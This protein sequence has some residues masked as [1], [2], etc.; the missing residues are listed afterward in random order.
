MEK[1]IDNKAFDN[2]IQN[3]LRVL[4][5]DAQA[6]PELYTK[7][8]EA[9]EPLVVKALE[10]AVDSLNVNVE[11]KYNSGGYAFPDIVVI[12]E[13]GEKYGIEVKSSTAKGNS[14]K[15]NGNSVMGSTSEPGIIRNVIIFGK[16]RLRNCIFRAKDYEDSIANVVVTHSPRYYIDLDLEDGDTFFEK[17][18]ISYKDLVISENPIGL[19]TDYFSSQGHKAWWLAESTPAAIRQFGDLSYEEQ[20]EVLGYAF[21]HFPEIMSKSSTKFSR[22]TS[23]LATENSIVDASLRDKFTAGGKVDLSVSGHKY[24]RLPQIFSKMHQYRELILAELEI[25]DTDVLQKDWSCSI[26]DSAE[27]RKTKWIE[28]VSE[29]ISQDDIPNIQADELLRNIMED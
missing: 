19:I 1:N 22:F 12:A 9:F 25:C 6:H 7:S 24:N 13:T 18:N 21:V 2:L 5:Q 29:L 11:I 14:W 27:G 3:T 10:N 17:A 23:W 4:Y 15:I 28:L 20:A 8:G 26:P 16:L